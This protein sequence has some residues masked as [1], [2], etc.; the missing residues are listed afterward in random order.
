M[1]ISFEEPQDQLRSELDNAGWI[2][3]KSSAQANNDDEELYLCSVLI[4]K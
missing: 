3:V 2:E 1:D 4:Y